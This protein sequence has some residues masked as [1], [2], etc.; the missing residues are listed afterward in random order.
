MKLLLS[1]YSFAD[2]VTNDKRRIRFQSE[3][4]YIVFILIA[5]VMSIINVFSGET[6]LLIATSSFCL[7][8]ALNLVLTLIGEKTQAIASYLFMVEV[9]V[10][11]SYFII[12]GGTDNFS[13]VWL[14]LLPTIGLL[15]FGMARGTVMCAVI[16]VIM[17]ACFYV[18]PL[19]SLFKCTDYGDTFTLR[20]P[21]V[22]ICSYAVSLLLEA[23]RS[24]TARE[25]AVIRGQYEHLYSHD[26]LTGVYNRHGLSDVIKSSGNLRSASTGVIIFDIDHFKN[27]NDTYG[28]LNGDSILK[29]LASFASK[30]I[31]ERADIFRWGGEEF[32]VLYYNS[33]N[34]TENAEKLLKAVREHPFPIDSGNIN[35][36]I[37]IGLATADDCTMAD[38]YS[39]LLTLADKCLYQ[40]KEGG[41]DRIVSAKLN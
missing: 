25:L 6:I 10:L 28:H 11:F 36:T 24:V 31:P 41:R 38:V 37:S 16:L 14:L 3:L 9:I 7:L 32:T 26:A 27:V 34:A 21:V 15:F 39:N 18:E 35:I 5:L 1:D 4:I 22:F 29:E 8:C 40:A 23:V 19:R 17:L 20:F 13:I 30:I 33:E 12:T 2:I